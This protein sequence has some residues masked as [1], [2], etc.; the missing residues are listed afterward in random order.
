MARIAWTRRAI[1][2]WQQIID[3][4]SRSSPARAAKLGVRLREAPKRLAHS[5]KLGG[6]V[7][8]FDVDHVRELVTVRP[9]RIIYVLGEDVCTIVAVVHSKRNLQQ[10]FTLADLEEI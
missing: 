5:P 2:E 4:V 6:R 1:R 10:L 9:Y 7:P 3:Y 8:E